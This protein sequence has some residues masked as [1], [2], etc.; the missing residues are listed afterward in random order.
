MKRTW[1]KWIALSLAIGILEICTPFVLYAEEAENNT[2][3]ATVYANQN[4]TWTKTNGRYWYR[5][6]DGSCAKDGIYTIDGAQYAFDASGWMV[7]GW[8]K[9]STSTWYYFDSSGKMVHGWLQLGSKRYYMDLNDGHMYVDTW[10]WINKHLY[11]FTTDGSVHTGWYKDVY[12]DNTYDWLYFDADGKMH[13]G[14]LQLG[15][16]WYYMHPDEGWMYADTPLE[17]DGDQYLFTIDGTMFTGW[18][19]LVWTDTDFSWFY[20]DSNGKQHFGWL[21]SGPNWYYLDSENGNMYMDTTIEIN[22][23]I[24]KF[25]ADGSMYT[26][27]F[28]Y[29]GEKYYFD[30]SGKLHLGW[31]QLGTKWYYMDKSD[32]YMIHDTAYIIDNKTYKFNTDGTMFTG[33]CQNQDDWYYFAKSGAMQKG[34]LHLGNEWYYMD[35]KDGYMNQDC[36]ITLNGSRYHF[37][38]GGTMHV[39]W[40]EYYWY[41]DDFIGWYYYHADGKEH[42][43]W[44]TLDGKTYYMDPKNGSMYHSRTAIIDGKS[45]TFN[46]D[47]TL[48]Q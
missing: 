9:D 7:T 41:E 36:W 27:W 38:Q 43:G 44:L 48:K 13:C 32:G 19:K 12:D 10:D 5:Y 26:G 39:G 16:K 42:H 14:W 11:V 33:W 40:L 22:G 3:P 46:K 29:Q 30:P 31:L 6:S 35:E 8:Y 37:D 45:Y 28:E 34:W 18:Y 20:F 2:M 15:N 47:G 21:Q 23:N 17:I 4:G 24:Y 25:N 1:K